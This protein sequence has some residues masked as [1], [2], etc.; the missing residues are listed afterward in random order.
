MNHMLKR[1]RKKVSSGSVPLPVAEDP[2][3]PPAGEH[4]ES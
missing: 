4:A 2:P 1:R 3:A